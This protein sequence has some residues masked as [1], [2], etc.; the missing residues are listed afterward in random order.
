MNFRY[1]LTQ[2]PKDNVPD[3]DKNYFH[4]VGWSDSRTEIV[5]SSMHKGLEG[6]EIWKRNQEGLYVR[7]DLSASVSASKDVE[8]G[9]ALLLRPHRSIN[10]LY[11]LVAEDNV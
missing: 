2:A 11:V 1:L 10:D 8:F 7:I 3:P 4:V 6:S 5:M 9:N